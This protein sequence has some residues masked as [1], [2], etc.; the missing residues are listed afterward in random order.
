MVIVKVA[1]RDALLVLP[2]FVK[3]DELRVGV[4]DPLHLEV[5]PLLP[6][7]ARLLE[8]RRESGQLIQA[9]RSAAF[10]AARRRCDRH[11]RL[12]D[13]ARAFHFAAVG[14]HR[15]C[16]AVRVN[17]RDCAR[18]QHEESFAHHCAAGSAVWSSTHEH[19]STRIKKIL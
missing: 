3:N 17:R 19:E 6:P 1:E 10:D 12:K 14:V 13:L 18:Q 4:R 15:L 11:A 8:V 2:I 9:S 7:L 16:L 5:L